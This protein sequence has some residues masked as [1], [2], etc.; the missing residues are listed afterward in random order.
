MIPLKDRNVRVV[1]L[2]SNDHSR[3]FIVSLLQT[4]GLTDV[5]AF[6]TAEESIASLETG[7]GGAVAEEGV[8]A[9]AK[10]QV[11]IVENARGGMDGPA[12]VRYLRQVVGG[13]LAYLP[14]IMIAA[15]ADRETVNRARNAGVNEF[16]AKPVSAGGLA[17]RL[18]AV[19]DA[20]RPFVRT[21]DYFGPDRRR[22][23]ITF[24]GPD[25]RSKAP[26][27]AGT[28]EKDVSGIPTAD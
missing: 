6:A 5:D 9:K 10:G 23:Q 1:V 11:L 24:T 14:V 18:Q 21:G 26:E 13:R 7:G 22:R 16:M 20:P 25:R 8:V 4:I 27:G 15:R 17:A 3:Q 19:L 28:P 12:F 2:D